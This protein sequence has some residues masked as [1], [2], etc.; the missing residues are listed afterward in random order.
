MIIVLGK[1]KVFA[2]MFCHV[3]YLVDNRASWY[4]KEQLHGCVDEN[5]IKIFACVKCGLVV[6]LISYRTQGIYA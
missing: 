2:E 4:R 5:Y 1:E 3:S 6:Y